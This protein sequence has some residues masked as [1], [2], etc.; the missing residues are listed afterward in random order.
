MKKPKNSGLG[1][2]LKALRLNRKM[3]MRFLAQKANMQ[4]AVI[5]RLEAGRR[6]GINTYTLRRLAV[7]LGCSCDELVIGPLTSLGGES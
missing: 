7:A 1:Q 4:E 6:D 2:R 5:S 3:T